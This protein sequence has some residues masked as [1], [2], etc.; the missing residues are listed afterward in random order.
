MHTQVSV[1]ITPQLTQGLVLKRIFVFLLLAFLAERVCLIG[2]TDN[3]SDY[4]IN[5][6]D[7]KIETEPK[8]NFLAGKYLKNVFI[9]LG[10]YFSEKGNKRVFRVGATLE[11]VK[12]PKEERIKGLIR[13]YENQ[14]TGETYDRRVEHIRL[15][16]EKFVKLMNMKNT[17]TTETQRIYDFVHNDKARLQRRPS[18]KN[19]NYRRTNG[20]RRQETNFNLG[21]LKDNQDSRRSNFIN[22]MVQM[23]ETVQSDMNKDQQLTDDSIEDRY[24]LRTTETY[25]V[26]GIDHPTRLIYLQFYEVY[27]GLEFVK[28][29][30]F[31]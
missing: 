18:S 2:Q 15:N 30:S 14:L 1:I 27:L 22:S 17:F 31:L 13:D 11:Y 20:L 21:D 5:G 16:K 23:I 3:Q 4:L 7:A 28:L 24:Y 12:Q 10:P 29:I 9:T 8:E 19:I 25:K 6:P 26:M